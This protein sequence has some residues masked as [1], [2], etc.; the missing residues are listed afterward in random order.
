MR[1]AIFG[2]GLVAALGLGGCSQSAQTGEVLEPQQ[3]SWLSGLLTPEAPGPERVEAIPE[4]A[5]D[6]RPLLTQVIE[7]GLE[8]AT[9]GVILRVRGLAPA[10]GWYNVALV[11]E[12]ADPT[13]SAQS[14]L[15]QA[16]SYRLVG[17]PPP[18]PLGYGATGREVLTAT[19]IPARRLAN[20]SDVRVIAQDGS[21][22]LR[23]P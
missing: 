17:L 13:A 16:G 5:V 20:L 7:A 6:P 8:P 18:A 3:S 21:R 2:L 19:F 4:R 14:T 9:G 15:D 12:V 11:P 10:P 23:L 1:Q 22:S